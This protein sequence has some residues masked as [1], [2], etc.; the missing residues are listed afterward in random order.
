MDA[1]V[2]QEPSDSMNSGNV[3][4]STI[5]LRSWYIYVILDI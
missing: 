4:R 1:D 3:Y 2:E 5:P